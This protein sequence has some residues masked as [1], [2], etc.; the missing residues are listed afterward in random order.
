MLR[1]QLDQKWG[2]PQRE[3]PD[4][5]RA[6]LRA[7]AAQPGVLRDG[8][9]ACGTRVRRLKPDGGSKTSSGRTSPG[10]P[11]PGWSSPLPSPRRESDCPGSC[12]R[13]KDTWTLP[14]HQFEVQRTSLAISCHSERPTLRYRSL[15]SPPSSTT[16]GAKRSPTR[17]PFG[18]TMVSL[19]ERSNRTRN[20]V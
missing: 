18:R 2:A 16:P 3:L 10:P 9:S 13:G 5:S 1:S 12:V 7:E 4:H 15:N 14:A 11:N 8:L 20:S 19:V 17:H 6:L